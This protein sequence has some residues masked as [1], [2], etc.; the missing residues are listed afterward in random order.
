[1]GILEALL[2]MDGGFMQS[3][4]VLYRV[5]E[6]S[7]TRP[8]VEFIPSPVTHRKLLAPIPRNVGPQCK[9]I[10]IVLGAVGDGFWCD[11]NKVFLIFAIMPEVLGHRGR[12]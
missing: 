11:F 5:Y 7:D 6:L 12:K 10:I 4:S 9:H 2:L 8:P 3:A 1:M